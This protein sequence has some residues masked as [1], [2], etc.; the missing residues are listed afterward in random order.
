[1][2][3][4]SDKKTACREGADSVQK[5]IDELRTEVAII[6][7]ALAELGLQNWE[8]LRERY[9]QRQGERLP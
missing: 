3:A 6:K 1:M 7:E 9:A 5:Q 2:D 8:A 4:V